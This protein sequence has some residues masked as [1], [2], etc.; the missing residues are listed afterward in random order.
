MFKNL[1]KEQIEIVISE[2]IVGRLGCHADGKTYV[3][4]VSYAV[5]KSWIQN[6]IGSR[7]DFI[8]IH[9][10]NV[11]KN[12]FMTANKMRLIPIDTLNE[13]PD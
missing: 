9:V 13:Q 6:F 7:I 10:L 5:A 4:P 11:L 2:N 3:I 8:T 12:S 1:S